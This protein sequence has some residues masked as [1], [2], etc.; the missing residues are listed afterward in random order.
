MDRLDESLIGILRLN[1]RESVAEIAR[2]LNT[3]RSTVQD[4]L[5]RLEESGA[6]QGY[7]IRLNDNQTGNQIRAFVTIAVEPQRTAMIIS[8][9]K[10]INAVNSVHTVSGKFDLHLEIM[11]KDTTEMDK[12]LDRLVEIPG[13]I[14]TETSIVLS[15]KIKR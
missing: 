7:S 5:K 15:T 11:T 6:I 10:T 2:Q 4:R 14:R 3:S 1:A 8:E 13:V 9:L 12:T